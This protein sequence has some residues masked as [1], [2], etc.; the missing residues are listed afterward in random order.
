MELKEVDGLDR[1]LGWIKNS[2][3][4]LREKKKKKKNLL[5]WINIIAYDEEKQK[6]FH[7]YT[8]RM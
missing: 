4:S 5:S 3:F 7:V 1:K 2:Q 8:I 6:S